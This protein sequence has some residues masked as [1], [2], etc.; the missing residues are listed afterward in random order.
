METSWHSSIAL[1][2]GK[3]SIPPLLIR[4][5]CGNLGVETLHKCPLK[6]NA[7]QY[8]VFQRL[9]TAN[10]VFVRW[11]AGQARPCCTCVGP[12]RRRLIL[13]RGTRSLRPTIPNT[14]RS[15]EACVAQ[16]PANL[17]WRLLGLG[18]ALA[19]QPTKSK[20]V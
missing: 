8:S 16:R 17:C 19:A 20:H 12:G 3:K 15:P 1:R 14:H 13:L 18:P 4:W 10:W 7:N 11:N 5:I 9:L 6:S 2:C